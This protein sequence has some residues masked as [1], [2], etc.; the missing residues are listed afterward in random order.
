VNRI[1]SIVQFRNK[2]NG[3]HRFGEISGS[4]T[5]F[6]MIRKNKKGNNVKQQNKAMLRENFDVQYNEET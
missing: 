4:C 6:P 5:W 1:D 2:T 3:H